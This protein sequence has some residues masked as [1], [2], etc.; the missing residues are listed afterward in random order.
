MRD[1]EHWAR[2]YWQECVFARRHRQ[3]CQ[4]TIE[5]VRLLQG[6][7][8]Y[9]PGHGLLQI[10]FLVTRNHLKQGMKGIESLV[11]VPR[12]KARGWI[13]CQEALSLSKWIGDW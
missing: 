4:V 6:N 7:L 8:S 9:Q 11:R 12:I 2:S 10:E 13:L 5:R 3:V 1:T